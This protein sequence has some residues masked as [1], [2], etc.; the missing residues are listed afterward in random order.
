MLEPP[1]VTRGP[2]I[3]TRASA[4]GHWCPSVHNGMY[5]VWWSQGHGIFGRRNLRMAHLILLIQDDPVVAGAI[6]NALSQSRDQAF[7]VAW[8]RRCSDALQRLE[9][10]AAILVD[11]Y[12][13]DSRGIKTF[14]R[15][16]EAAPAIPIAILAD[17]QN[18]ETAKLA[19]QCGAQDYLLKGRLDAYL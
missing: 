6:L 7:E 13:P 14:D 17:S 11:L 5:Q 3:Q 10:V 12:L 2:K 9:G 1:T 19:V 8:V 15:L 18:E 4:R 16:Y